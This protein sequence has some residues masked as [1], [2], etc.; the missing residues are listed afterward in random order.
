MITGSQAHR[1]LL[2]NH[3]LPLLDEEED[4]DREDV[5]GSNASEGDNGE[6]GNGGDG[7]MRNSTSNSKGSSE[8]TPT[9][10]DPT[11]GGRSYCTYKKGADSK[12][13]SPVESISWGRGK[14][15]LTKPRT[16][17]FK[18]SAK[19][20]HVRGIV[21]RTMSFTT[22]AQTLPRPTFIGTVVWEANPTRPEIVSSSLP[23]ST[24]D[25]IEEHKGPTVAEVLTMRPTPPSVQGPIR[26]PVGVP[27]TP[28][29]DTCNANAPLEDTTEGELEVGGTKTPT[30][31]VEIDTTKD[32]PTMSLCISAIAS[33]GAV[34][35]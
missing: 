9:K 31:M 27:N 14:G 22:M 29:L 19:R 24:H 20:Q 3:R 17:L 11:D 35:H 28:A 7:G 16:N 33:F 2:A 34:F 6:G 12:V 18:R 13:D 23:M 8:R 21:L 1:L 5:E 26:E 30:S 4:D 15:P 10:D 32:T 25:N